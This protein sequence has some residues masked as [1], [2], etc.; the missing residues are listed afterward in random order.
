MDWTQIDNITVISASDIGGITDSIGISDEAR[1]ILCIGEG[2]LTVL[3]GK[4]EFPGRFE[5]GVLSWSPS[6]TRAVEMANTS[7]RAPALMLL[8]RSDKDKI[9]M[10]FYDLGFNDIP[11]RICDL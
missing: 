1:D 2:D 5:K 7:D 8:E 4:K 6:V 3:I 11:L 10:G 9:G